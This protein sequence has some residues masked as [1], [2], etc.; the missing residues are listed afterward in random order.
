MG[1]LPRLEFDMLETC[2]YK[3]WLP[4]LPNYDSCEKGSPSD[5]M[6]DKFGFESFTPP[7]SPEQ[8]S[9]VANSLSD[10]LSRSSS[11]QHFDTVNQI[12]S[13]FTHTLPDLKDTCNEVFEQDCSNKLRKDCM[14]NGNKDAQTTLHRRGRS[15]SPA[16]LSCSP[17]SSGCIDPRAL[18]NINDR[19]K[20]CTTHRRFYPDSGPETPSDSGE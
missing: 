15:D 8:D 1:T 7:Q 20:P 10:P 2:G 17:A 6:W 13:D 12:L 16:G 5:E 3:C 11:P 4:E 18:F 14:W 19:V 9:D